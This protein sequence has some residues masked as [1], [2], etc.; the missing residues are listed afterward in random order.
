MLRVAGRR[1]TSNCISESTSADRRSEPAPP[2]GWRRFGVGVPTLGGAP[3]GDTGDSVSCS[4]L[5]TLRHLRAHSVEVPPAL[6]RKKPINRHLRGVFVPAA[7]KSDRG[8]D[9]HRPCR[10]LDRTRD[11]RGSCS[12]SNTWSRYVIGGQAE[13]QCCRN[14]PMHLNDPRRGRFLSRI[15]GVGR[16]QRSHHS[17]CHASGEDKGSNS[18][19]QRASQTF[20]SR[21]RRYCIRRDYPAPVGVCGDILY[22]HTVVPCAPPST[23]PAAKG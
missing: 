5:R 14:G 17:G 21:P 1:C 6:S 9:R 4:G 7:Y 2:N 22:E 20:H 3:V 18:P 16:R 11:Q 15:A 10:T 13:V 12:T 19:Y 23:A 8:P